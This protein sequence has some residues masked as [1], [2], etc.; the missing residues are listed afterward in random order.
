MLAL[1]VV[2]LHFVILE[3]L[4]QNDVCRGDAGGDGQH[5]GP[6]GKA[7]DGECGLEPEGGGC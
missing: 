2:L 1:Y 5:A 6:A 4:A 3:L 7:V